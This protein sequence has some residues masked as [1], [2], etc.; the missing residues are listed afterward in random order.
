MKFSD[1]RLINY[2]LFMKTF[3]IL[4]NFSSIHHFKFNRKYT[5][6]NTGLDIITYGN[7]LKK[8]HFQI[9]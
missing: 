8:C 7:I 3:N 2:K 6:H 5:C 1:S 9:S 4:N